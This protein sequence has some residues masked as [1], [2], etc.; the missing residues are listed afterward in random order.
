VKNGPFQ[1]PKPILENL[2]AK[3]SGF[4]WVRFDKQNRRVTCE[5][6]P[7]DDIGGQ[8]METWPVTV[9]ERD[10]YGKQAKAYLPRLKFTNT[11]SAVVEVMDAKRAELLY[12]LRLNTDSWQPH[13]FAEGEYNLVISEPEAGVTKEITGVRALL[14]NPEVLEI[15]LG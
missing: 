9:S 8:Q 13:V 5:C 11:S 1:P 10:Q 3:T 12:V 14:V 2:R 15:T 7:L 4:G 6:W